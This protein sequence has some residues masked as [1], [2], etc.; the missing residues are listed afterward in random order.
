MRSGR[1]Y[2]V[3]YL[4][5]GDQ[6]RMAPQD[7]LGTSS[8]GNGDAW[9]TPATETTLPHHE[10]TL[11]EGIKFL[12]DPTA[13]SDP[14]ASADQQTPSLGDS[15]DG[16]SEPILFYPD[17]TTSNARLMLVNDRNRTLRLVLRGLT[18]TVTVSDAVAE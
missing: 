5:G 2:T 7:E 15:G 4:V 1:T 12:V 6:F 3:R 9:G 13:G 17:G 14:T 11:P 18:G 16:W 8:S 10:K